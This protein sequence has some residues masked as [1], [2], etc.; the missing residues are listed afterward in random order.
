[1]GNFKKEKG[2]VIMDMRLHDTRVIVHSKTNPELVKMFSD[3]IDRAKKQT[4]ESTK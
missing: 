1:M 2:R 3:A 4:E